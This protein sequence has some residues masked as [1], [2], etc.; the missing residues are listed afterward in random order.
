M[1]KSC[2]LPELD[3]QSYKNK[4]LKI[5]IQLDSI[6]IP[7]TIAPENERKY[8]IFGILMMSEPIFIAHRLS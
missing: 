3:Y 5:Q 6:L 2:H 1:F 7:V 8:R 4:T